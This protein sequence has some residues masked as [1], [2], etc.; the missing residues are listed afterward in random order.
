[1]WFKSTPLSLLLPFHRLFRVTVLLMSAQ[2]TNRHYSK[3]PHSA[4]KVKSQSSTQRE[5]IYNVFVCFSP[6]K[7]FKWNEFSSRLEESDFFFRTQNQGIIILM[8]KHLFGLFLCAFCCFCLLSSAKQTPKKKS[9][10]F[11]LTSHKLSMKKRRK[12]KARRRKT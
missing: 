9:W 12:N 6:W 7:I 5:M 4:V 1:M 11:L 10:K 8:T 2:V 3:A